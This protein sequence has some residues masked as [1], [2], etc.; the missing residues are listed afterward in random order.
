MDDVVREHAD[1]VSMLR[2]KEEVLDA[3][4]ELFVGTDAKEWDRVRAVLAPSVRFDMKSLTGAEPTTISSDEIV[5]GWEQGLRPI[6]A[7]HHQTGNFRVRL[8]GDEADA[9]CYGTATHYLPN[10]SGRNT[11]TFVGSYDFHLRREEGAWRIDLFRFHV[12]F[13]DGNLRLEEER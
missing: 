4:N 3:I 8:H 13:I 5:A 2:A 12:K 9:F 10:P 11:R 6:A 7:V 1:I